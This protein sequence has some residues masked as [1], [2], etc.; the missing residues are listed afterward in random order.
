MTDT[1]DRWANAASE[2]Y[3]RRNAMRALGLGAG[4]AVAAACSSPPT[5]TGCANGQTTCGGTCVDLQ[6]D[7]ANCGT[8]GTHCPP[9]SGQVCVAGVCKCPAGYVNCSGTCVNPVSDP[10]NCGACG[11]TCTAGKTC[12]AGT[13]V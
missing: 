13:C 12:V 4:A 1:F 6:T 8:C 11:N 3:S 7:V 10:F 5:A 2:R 9:F